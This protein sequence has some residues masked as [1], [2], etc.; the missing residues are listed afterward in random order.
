MR[1][2]LAV[3]LACFTAVPAVPQG[4]RFGETIE[5]ALVNVDVLVTDRAGNHVR[6][7][8]AA[9]FELYENGKPQP[10]TNFAEYRGTAAARAVTT[11][12]TATPAPASEQAAPPQK[13]NILVFID[14]LQVHGRERRQLF[15]GIKQF[16]RRSVRPGDA[17]GI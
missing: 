7:L 13:R 9:D 15:D 10:I 4:S 12:T 17:V 14:K 1:R 3:L 2:L 6:G 16:L 8:T 11:G 5:V